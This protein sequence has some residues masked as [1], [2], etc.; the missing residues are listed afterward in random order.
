[1]GRLVKM[2]IKLIKS[3]WYMRKLKKR[4]KDLRKQDPFIYD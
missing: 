1:M 3:W 4:M 2:I